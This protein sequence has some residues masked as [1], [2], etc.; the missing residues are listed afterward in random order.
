MIEDCES[1]T[2]CNDTKLSG[3]CNVNDTGVQLN[4]NGTATGT[5]LNITAN[6]TQLNCTVNGTVNTGIQLNCTNGT[7]TQ[8][9]CTVTELNSSFIEF[10]ENHN[11]TKRRLEDFLTILNKTVIGVLLRDDMRNHMSRCE[12]RSRDIIY[13]CRLA[14]GVLPCM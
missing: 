9:D 5:Q 11:K 10:R 6:G 13:V 12:V 1:I 8:L 3:R 4:F 7:G 14:V 2:K